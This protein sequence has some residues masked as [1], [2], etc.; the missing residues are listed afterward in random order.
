MALRCAAARRGS[1]CAQ[2]FTSLLRKLNLFFGRPSVLYA[3]PVSQAPIFLP[4]LPCLQENMT[5]SLTPLWRGFSGLLMLKP[6]E[7]SA[8]EVVRV[9]N[10]SPSLPGENLIEMIWVCGERCVNIGIYP[11]LQR[12]C[13]RQIRH[14][15]PS[16]GIA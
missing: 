14:R 11:E 2:G 9:Q 5:I 1:G 10:G 15:N 16:V 3:T 7:V 13:Q 4:K 8:T 6:A 12:L